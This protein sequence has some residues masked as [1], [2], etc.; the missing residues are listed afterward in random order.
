MIPDALI[1]LLGAELVEG[2]IALA[3]ARQGKRTL[4][5]CRDVQAP[6]P[7][8]KSLFLVKRYPDRVQRL[9]AISQL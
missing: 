1:A 6:G 8:P 5:P 7:C 3:E 4:R 2:M 9:A